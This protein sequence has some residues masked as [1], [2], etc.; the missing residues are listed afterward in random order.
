MNEEVEQVYDVDPH[1]YGL[2]DVVID[3]NEEE[4]FLSMVSGL[5]VR[6]YQMSPKLMKRLSLLLNIH[7]DAYEKEHGVLDTELTPDPGEETPQTIG[8]HPK[9]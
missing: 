3:S 4:F 5:S 9:E 2:A 6:N 7:V 8:F 1:S